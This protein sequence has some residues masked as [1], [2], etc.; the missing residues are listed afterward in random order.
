MHAGERATDRTVSQK[1]G[2]ERSRRDLVI[3]LSSEAVGRA[4]DVEDAD[5]VERGLEM[6]WALTLTPAAPRLTFPDLPMP[7]HNSARKL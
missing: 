1:D 6:R 5:P 2:V 7:T 3:E 4:G